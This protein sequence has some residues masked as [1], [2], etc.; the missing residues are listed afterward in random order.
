MKSK[1]AALRSNE[2]LDFVRRDHPASP[3][4]SWL[5]DIIRYTH[6]P[7]AI[8]LTKELILEAVRG[9]EHSSWSS[10]QAEV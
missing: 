6:R 10:T 1:L 4:P 5:I 7:L 3:E 9:S 8:H 2:L